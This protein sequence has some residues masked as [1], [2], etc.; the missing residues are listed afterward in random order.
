[1]FVGGELDSN[2]ESKGLKEPKE[3]LRFPNRIVDYRKPPGIIENNKEHEV[4]AILKKRLRKYRRGFS[5][6][7]LVHWKGYPSEELNH[8][9]LWKMQLAIPGDRT[10]N[11]TPYSS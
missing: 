9:P 8:I 3:A 11:S 5:R 2:F 10:E 6:E 1:M 4:E 7:Y